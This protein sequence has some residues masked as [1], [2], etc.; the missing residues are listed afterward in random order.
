LRG[1]GRMVRAHASGDG[2]CGDV[3][4][5]LIVQ[6][7]VVLLVDVANLGTGLGPPF[8]DPGLQRFVLLAA[9]QIG[10][11]RDAREFAIRKGQAGRLPGWWP[12]PGS[13]RRVS[14]LS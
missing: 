1:N 3:G 2:A 7:K 12:L 9:V 13:C 5:E 11:N 10:F 6:F 14:L 8:R 4:L